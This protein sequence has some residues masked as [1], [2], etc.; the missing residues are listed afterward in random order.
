[1]VEAFLFIV[2]H[3][4]LDKALNAKCEIFKN[5][6]SIK[7]TMVW[8]KEFG[9]D[10]GPLDLRPNTNLVGLEEYESR[11]RN[12]IE[13]E[14]IC[15]LNGLTGSGKTSLLKKIQGSMPDHK[16]IY[17]DAQDVP[18]NFDLE[19]EIRNKRSFIDKL[20]LKDHPSKKPVLIIDE[21]QETDKN[22]ILQARG[23]WEDKSNQ[24][25]K[26]IVICQIRKQLRNVTP[27]F[28]E[29]LGS[30]IITLKTLDDDEMKEILRIRLKMKNGKNL[31]DKLDPKAVELIVACA[32]G[33]PRR[34]LEYTDMIFDF[35]YN[36][37]TTK[38]PLKTDHYRV[39]YWGAREILDLYQVN[40]NAHSVK[41]TEPKSR[42]GESLESLFSEEHQKVLKFFMTGAKTTDELAQYFQIP[43]TRAHTLIK[44]LRKK[45][46]IVAAGRKNKKKLWQTS[47]HVR[48]LT[49]NE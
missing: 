36:K 1:M 40:V 42:N 41:V 46:A 23:K 20:R 2:S 33:N 32:D 12:H 28:K 26:S 10:K 18:L 13:K 34:L 37:F 5:R 45:D 9:F 49:V 4:F 30:R 44:E 24:R 48:R 31:Y 47:Q 25:I 11:I 21:F 17:L 22:L 39:S 27:A 43:E 38:N 35:H 8:F 29:R 3:W 16:F 7:Y 15:F 19:E 14:E 6:A